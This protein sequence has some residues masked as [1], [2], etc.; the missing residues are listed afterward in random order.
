MC[1]ARPSSTADFVYEYLLNAPSANTDMQLLPGVP[2]IKQPRALTKRNAIEFKDTRNMA[3]ADPGRTQLSLTNEDS[4]VALL[5][6]AL[7]NNG[8][9]ET[10]TS[11]VGRFASAAAS[12]PLRTHPS[13][14]PLD[15][16]RFPRHHSP[17]GERLAALA[18]RDV[19]P[20]AQLHRP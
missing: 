12:A 9:G 17:S 13:T 7:A 5:P 6:S 8:R 14:I 19:Q 4:G 20:V 18:R 3:G 16:P 10:A 2:Q 1:A 15:T 11:E